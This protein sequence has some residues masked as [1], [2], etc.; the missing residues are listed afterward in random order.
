MNILSD[1]SRGY[2]ISTAIREEK[3]RKEGK[4]SNVS[5]VTEIFPTKIEDILKE[6]NE[7]LEKLKNKSNMSISD[8]IRL[9]TRLQGLTRKS[10]SL[11]FNTKENQTNDL[12]EHEIIERLNA[13]GINVTLEELAHYL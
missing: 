5:L 1:L 3:L 4:L 13:Q 9:E 11:G 12:I 7:I 2:A 8:I 10:M 6:Q